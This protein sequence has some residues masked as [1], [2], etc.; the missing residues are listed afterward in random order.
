MINHFPP[1]LVIGKQIEEEK[2]IFETEDENMKVIL[3]EIVCE[4]NYSNPTG[5]FNL[6]L[7][8]IDVRTSNY[9]SMSYQQYKQSMAAKDKMEA[10]EKERAE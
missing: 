8:H 7:P 2:V 9:Q 1:H 4:Y 6:S 10:M 5:M 3:S